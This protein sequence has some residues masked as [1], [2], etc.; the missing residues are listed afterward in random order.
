MNKHTDGFKHAPTYE[1]FIDLKELVDRHFQTMGEHIAALCSRLSYLEEHRLSD[2]EL[3]EM[4]KK[5]K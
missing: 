5:N 1:E 4:R 2:R 3:D